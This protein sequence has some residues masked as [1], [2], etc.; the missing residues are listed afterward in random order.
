MTGQDFT[1]TKETK[2][3]FLKEVTGNTFPAPVRNKT[4]SHGL[5]IWTLAFLVLGSEK[6]IK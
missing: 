5:G 3:F 2:A 4:D 6:C 1:E